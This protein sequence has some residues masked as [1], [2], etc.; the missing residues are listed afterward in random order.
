MEGYKKGALRK[1]LCIDPFI[2]RLKTAT[3][4]SLTDKS[5]HYQDQFT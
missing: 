2:E 5:Y 4:E 3:W 1:E